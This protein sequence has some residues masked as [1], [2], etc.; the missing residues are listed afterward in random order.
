MD[1]NIHNNAKTIFKAVIRDSLWTQDII[2]LS[3]PCSSMNNNNHS[4]IC[5]QLIMGDVAG[6]S[7]STSMVSCTCSWI[8]RYI[9]K[10]MYIHFVT[11]ITLILRL[12]CACIVLDYLLILA[13]F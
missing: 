12:F 4:S 2:Q 3:L 5:I 10:Y 9:Y 8:V 6:G 7:S 13:Y 11:H 1:N